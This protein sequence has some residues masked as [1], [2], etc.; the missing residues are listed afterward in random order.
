MPEVIRSTDLAGGT[1]SPKGQSRLRQFWAR[2][3]WK[4]KTGLIVGAIFLLLLVIGFAAPAEEEAPSEPA[5]A[6]AEPED[7]T[8][9]EATAEESMTGETETGEAEEATGTEPPPQPPAP[10]VARV[11]DG[12]TI[13]LNTG[14]R[15][16]LVQIDAPEARGE[17]YGQKAGAVLRQILPQGTKVRVMADP[18]LDDVDRFGRLLRYVFTGNNNVNLVL[19]QRGAASVWFFDGD[20]GQYASKL[21][22]AAKKAR[23]AEKGAWG[24][25]RAKLDSLR[26]FQTRKPL[27]PAPPPAPRNCHPSYR[28]ECLDPSVSDYD[29]AGGSGNGPGYVYGTVRVVGSDPYGLDAD[30]DGYGCE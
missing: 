20:R 30:G 22:A 28:G 2:R 14:D 27:P 19:V 18:G 11:T 17:C 10:K 8:S 12:D 26:P 29:C 7:T 24:A 9:E 25:C 3:S 13:V 1:P 16:R 21:L 6:A 4:G 23:T 5:A 15:V